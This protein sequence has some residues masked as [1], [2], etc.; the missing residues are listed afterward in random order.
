MA[1]EYRMIDSTGKLIVLGVNIRTYDVARK[2][3]SVKWLD[4]LTGTW[5]DLVREDL[6]GIS[7]HGQSLSYAFEEPMADHGLTRATYT[8]VSGDHF[9]WIGE[10][11]ED[12]KSW[13]E[14]MRLDAYR[15]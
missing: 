1:D 3:W 11:S 6:G 12:G 10:K 13:R 9:I 15:E 2:A 14:F 8:P 4:A 5:T 7:F